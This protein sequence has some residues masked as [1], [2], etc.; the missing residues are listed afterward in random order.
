M[1]GEKEGLDRKKEGGPHQGDVIQDSGN[2]GKNDNDSG[3]DSQIRQGFAEGEAADICKQ[4]HI[5][6]LMLTNRNA[7]C[8]VVI[9]SPIECTQISRLLG[10]FFKIF[11]N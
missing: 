11:V 4:V 3:N 2:H 7:H 5:I 8:C 10:D 1:P 6:Y 9:F